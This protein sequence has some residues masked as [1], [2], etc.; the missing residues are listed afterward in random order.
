VEEQGEASV[1][2]KQPPGIMHGSKQT[3][4]VAPVQ[5]PAVYT[6]YASIALFFYFGLVSLKEAI[7]QAKVCNNRDASV[8]ARYSCII[9][10][11]LVA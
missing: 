7:F 11:A 3:E 4:I 10:Y 1:T 6:H 2:S 9:C 5:I 8:L